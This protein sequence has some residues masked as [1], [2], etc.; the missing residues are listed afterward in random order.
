MD[1]EEAK[2]TVPIPNKILYNAIRCRRCGDVIESKHVHDFKMCKCG[3]V[4]VDGGHEYLRRIGPI[5]D[6]EELSE[7]ETSG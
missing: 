3:R 1:V 6:A 7:R 5:V 4:G 2:I